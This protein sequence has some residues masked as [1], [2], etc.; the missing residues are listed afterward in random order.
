MEFRSHFALQVMVDIIWCAVQIG[1]FEVMFMYTP[2]FAGLSRSE[3]YLFLGTLFI[4][5]S[6]NMTLVASNF[7]HFPRYVNTGELDFFL[8]K[9]VSPLF[10]SYFRFI[11]TS[12]LV[13]VAVS[14]IIFMMGIMMHDQTIG[15]LQWIG[16]FVGLICGSIILFSL[17][18]LI[19]SISFYFVN[20]SGVQNIFYAVYQIAMRPDGI[21]NSLMRRIFTT[22]FPLSLIASIPASM[23][24]ATA[25]AEMF[26]LMILMTIIT[27]FMSMKFFSIALKRYNGAS[28]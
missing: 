16:W 21:Y 1:F 13:N 18:A 26:G 19:G 22:I 28:S 5:D 20:A 25:S 17:E 14:I 10:L 6:L 11:N 23:L 7:W 24:F 8:L 3:A 9:P 12:S 2:S 4:V 27:A 15:I